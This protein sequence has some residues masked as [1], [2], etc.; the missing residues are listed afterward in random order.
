MFH[1]IEGKKLYVVDLVEEPARPIQSGGDPQL[2]PYAIALEHALTD[3][4]VKVPGKYGIEINLDND[5]YM[6]HQILE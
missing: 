1:V 5:T 3:G 6:I 2:L 4:M